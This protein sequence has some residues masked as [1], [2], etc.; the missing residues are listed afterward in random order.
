VF[1]G[2][3]E[4]VTGRQSLSVSTE[5]HSLQGQER[6]TLLR[7]QAD[8]PRIVLGIPGSLFQYNNNNNNNNNNNI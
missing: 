8:L 7:L 1:H 6:E 2:A 4:A 3:K 5:D